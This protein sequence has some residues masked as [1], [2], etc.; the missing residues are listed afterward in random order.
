M[1]HS[2]D[3]I[4]DVYGS[5]HN[6]L[7]LKVQYGSHDATTGSSLTKSQTSSAPNVHGN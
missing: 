2:L 5:I 4:S 6:S 1:A 3:D 7:E